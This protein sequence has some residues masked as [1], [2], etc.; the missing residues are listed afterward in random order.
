MYLWNMLNTGSGGEEGGC[1]GVS[2][3]EGIGG[4]RD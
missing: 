1:K 3:G 4:R 2:H